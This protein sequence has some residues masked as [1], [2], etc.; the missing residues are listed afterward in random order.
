[1]IKEIKLLRIKEVH[2]NTILIFLINNVK[3]V[4]NE[5]N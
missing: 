3:I 5:L 4:K 2:S 1:M